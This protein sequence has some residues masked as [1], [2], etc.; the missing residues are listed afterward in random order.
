MFLLNKL[1]KLCGRKKFW[2]ITNTRIK[3]SIQGRGFWLSG[4][5]VTVVMFRISLN[6]MEIFGLRLLYRVESRRKNMEEYDVVF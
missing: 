3:R 5:T 6:L 4:L 2:M 1:K